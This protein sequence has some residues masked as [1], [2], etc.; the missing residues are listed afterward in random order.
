MWLETLLGFGLAW[1]A[2][3][4]FRWLWSLVFRDDG[5]F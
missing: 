2:I 4:V 5:F 1:V 3:V